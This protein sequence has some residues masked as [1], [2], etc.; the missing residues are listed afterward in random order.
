MRA[1]G[2][3]EGQLAKLFNNALLMMNQASI[4]DIVELGRR[5]GLDPFAL[6]EGLKLVSATSAALTLLNTM[7]RPDT[8]KHLSR[9]EELDMGLFQEAMTDAGIEASQATARGLSGADRLP[10]LIR[11]L[12]Q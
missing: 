7:V 12:N 5:A 9:V 1:G 4:A 6:V 2:V 8:V 10:E 11:Q 3:G